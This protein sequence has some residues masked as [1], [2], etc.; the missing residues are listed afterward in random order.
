MKNNTLTPAP[1]ARIDANAAYELQWLANEIQG[2]ASEVRRKGLAGLCLSDVARL[3]DSLRE[4]AKE[5]DRI[6][7]EARRA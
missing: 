3:G 4:H 7:N 2:L 5:A 6:I 1:V